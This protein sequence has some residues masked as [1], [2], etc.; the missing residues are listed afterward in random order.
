MSKIL[1][2]SVV[3]FFFY[4]GF[5][6]SSPETRLLKFDYQLIVDN[7]V[8]AGDINQ[9]QYYSSGILPAF[10]FL[11]DSS[12][13]AK[14]IRTIQLNHIMYTPHDVRWR[15]ATSLDRPYAGLIYASVSNEY[16]YSHNRYLKTQLHLGWM[17]PATG[18]GK[19]QEA[20]HSLFG[21]PVPRGW[22]YQMKD[23]PVIN[24]DGTFSKPFF[25][26][27][28]FEIS[29]ES[30]ISMGTIYNYLRQ[31]FIIKSG[32]YKPINQSTFYGAILGQKASNH[33]AKA[34][35]LYWFY[36]PSLQYSFYNATIEGN[37]IGVKS[38]YTMTP[39]RLI[40]INRFGFMASYPRFDVGAILYVMTKENQKAK[41]HKYVGIRLNRRF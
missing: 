29:S 17:G 7:D 14:V 38:E 23:S 40:F 18:V 34:E 25:E 20:Y 2:S 37:F 30:M 4:T 13:N 3:L 1:L 32:R 33:T 24:L 26:N 10:R 35:E 9:D 15:K 28:N 31:S 21:M 19:L 5:S 36:S 39:T 8:F 27:E 22:K 12:F 6:Q 16:Y 41:Y 11:G